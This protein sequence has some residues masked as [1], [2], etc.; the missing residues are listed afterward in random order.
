MKIKRSYTIDGSEQNRRT[1]PKIEMKSLK[2]LR[3]VKRSDVETGKMAEVF[4][5]SEHEQNMREFFKLV[6][7]NIPSYL[8]IL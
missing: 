7:V 3:S 5:K 6:R 8:N 4:V 1:K 2:R